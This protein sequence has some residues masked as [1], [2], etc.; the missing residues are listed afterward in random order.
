MRGHHQD[1][2]KK[3]AR[4]LLSKLNP[5]DVKDFDDAEDFGILIETLRCLVDERDKYE[6]ELKELKQGG[7]K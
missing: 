2:I 4:Y 3:N 5:K 6:Q 7:T 1:V